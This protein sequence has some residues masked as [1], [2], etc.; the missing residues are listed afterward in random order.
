LCPHRPA[1]ST[2]LYSITKPANAMLYRA[3]DQWRQP[4]V[5]RHVTT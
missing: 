4:S 1:G 5:V 3:V 2:L